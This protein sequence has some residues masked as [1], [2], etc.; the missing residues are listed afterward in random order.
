MS[1]AQTTP[2]QTC[3]MQ[4]ATP[5]E[6][7]VARE[8][9]TRILARGWMISVD[10]GGE[11]VLARSTRL[12]TVLDSLA[13]TD[14]DILHVRD[15]EGKPMGWFHLVWGNDPSGEELIADHT[16]TRPCCEIAEGL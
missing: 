14:E 3:F 8:L 15:A 2:R 12:K 10:D 9:V 1:T 7:R 4:Y 13:G 11:F 6:R 5:G 16:A